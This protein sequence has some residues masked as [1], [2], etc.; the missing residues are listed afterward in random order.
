MNMKQYVKNTVFSAILALGVTPAVAQEASLITLKS[1]DG[2][3]T[4]IGELQGF[5]AGHYNIIVAGL[6]LMSIAEN[7]V[8]CQS[9][10]SDCTG[11]IS[12]S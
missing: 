9:E 4:I 8:T 2:K 6:G 12:N 1:L 3:V 7:L 10:G 11:L 5:E